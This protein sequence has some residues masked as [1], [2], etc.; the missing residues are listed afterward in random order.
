[1]PLGAVTFGRDTNSPVRLRW[2]DPAVG[3][4]PLSR[5][6][7]LRLAFRHHI[8]WTHA[9]RPSSAVLRSL[10]QDPLELQVGLP[11]EFGCGQLGA[12]GEVDGGV[13]GGILPDPGHA[14]DQ[15][16]NGL[17]VLVVVLEQ[18]LPEPLVSSGLPS[19]PPYQ[20]LQTRRL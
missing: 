7:L 6:P 12:V 1:M 3:L 16:P 11:S 18:G 10:P 5:P 15:H 8:S 19:V 20:T 14:I 13:R 4:V 9:D 2:Y 17:A